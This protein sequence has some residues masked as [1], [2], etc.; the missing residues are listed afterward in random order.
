MKQD[1]NSTT[2]MRVERAE[3]AEK[4]LNEI[5][6]GIQVDIKILKENIVENNETIEQRKKD[7]SSALA[8]W[9]SLRSNAED[10]HALKVKNSEM[11]KTMAILYS[12]LPEEE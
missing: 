12:L 3:K 8:D 5:I 2:R 1:S 4:R 7:C 9:Q 10:I 6:C 11:N